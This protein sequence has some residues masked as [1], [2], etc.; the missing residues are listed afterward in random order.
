M[1]ILYYDNETIGDFKVLSLNPFFSIC[2]PSAD[3]LSWT[4]Y[5]WVLVTDQFWEFANIFE[6]NNLIITNVISFE[7]LESE[8]CY[9]TIYNLFLQVFF[10]HWEM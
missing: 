2:H 6:N 4:A 3:E 8:S 1:H 5:A 7:R 9:S 10:C